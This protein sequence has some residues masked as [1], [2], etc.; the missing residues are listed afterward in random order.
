MPDKTYDEFATLAADAKPR[1]V[2]NGQGDTNPDDDF[3]S[4]RQVDAQNLF[5]NE[6]QKV[7]PARQFA[8]LEEWC[9]KATTEEMLDEGLRYA[10]EHFGV[11]HPTP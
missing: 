11:P 8:E 5:F 6:L 4:D 9:L 7:L 10:R 1:A 2:T 3:G